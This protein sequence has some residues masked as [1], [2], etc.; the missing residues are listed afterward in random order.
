[1][2]TSC[3]DAYNELPM[4]MLGRP[5]LRKQTVYRFYR[6][7]AI[8][9]ANTL[10]DPPFSAS[11]AFVLKVITYFMPHLP[12]TAGVFFTFRLFTCLAFLA[13]QG[14]FRTLNKVCTNFDS[15][16]CLATAVVPNMI[17]YGGYLIS[18]FNIKRW[19]FWLA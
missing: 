18:V 3:L 10:A 4:Q 5:I 12:W 13:M 16:F 17:T 11:R 14:F 15:A 19:L 9:L 8:A 6:L 2:L 7:G 1:M